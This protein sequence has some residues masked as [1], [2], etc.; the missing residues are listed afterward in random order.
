MNN[1][2]VY[3][4]GLMPYQTAWD[5]QK[6]WQQKL[7]TDPN[8]PDVLMLLE[9]PPVYTLGTGSSLEFVK[10][11]AGYELHRSERGGE[12][13][14]HC[15]GQLVIYPILNLRRHQMDLHWYLRQL[16]EVVIRLL[17][18]YELTSERIPGLTGVWL[19]EK[20]V[21]AI[22]IKVSRWIT[23][24]GLAINVNNDLSGF[25]Q[26]VPCGIKDRSVANLLEFLPGVSLAEVQEKSIEV[27][28]QVFMLK[29]NNKTDQ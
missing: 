4:L 16:E 2:Q 22:G 29:Y 17:A 19:K 15:P 5:L 7:I 1:I 11:N 13:T 6:Q 20:K 24:H 8:H 14:Y 27:F 18:D 10:F 21:A 26:I 3:K 12:V 25:E 9:H 28:C 23:M